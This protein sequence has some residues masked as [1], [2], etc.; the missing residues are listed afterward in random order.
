MEVFKKWHALIVVRDQGPPTFHVGRTWGNIKSKPQYGQIFPSLV[1]PHHA[2]LTT[3]MT[4]TTH[5]A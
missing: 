2:P 5:Y 4:K 3:A 1:I